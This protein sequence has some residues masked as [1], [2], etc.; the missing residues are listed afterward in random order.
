MSTVDY[1][2]TRCGVEIG[3][4]QEITWDGMK[5]FHPECYDSEHR[6][7]IDIEGVGPED[8]EMCGG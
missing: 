1:P 8:W 2:C 4:A 5:P 6:G 3:S 7:S